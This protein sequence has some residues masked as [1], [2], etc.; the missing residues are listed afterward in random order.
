MYD[1]YNKRPLKISIWESNLPNSF[2]W[3]TKLKRTDSGIS[4]YSFR[5]IISVIGFHWLFPYCCRKSLRGIQLYQ[6]TRTIRD[7]SRQHPL[8]SG[9]LNKSEQRVRSWNTSKY[10]HYEQQCTLWIKQ[11]TIFLNN[12]NLLK[13]FKYGRLATTKYNNCYVFLNR[14]T[15]WEKN[16]NSVQIGI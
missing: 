12:L 6:R 15:G 5:N 9:Y 11:Y 14:Q 16:R 3:S 7:C 10:F 2:K 1:P 4:S 8:W 13:R